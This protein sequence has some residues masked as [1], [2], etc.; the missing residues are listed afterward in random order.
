MFHWCKMTEKIKIGNRIIKFK[1]MLRNDLVRDILISGES[2]ISYSKRQKKLTT[3]IAARDYLRYY[4]LEYRH[5]KS[6]IK[7]NKDEM[8]MLE[9]RIGLR[10]V[11]YFK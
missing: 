2:G 5:L 10:G 4:N 1:D 3:K 9:E 6:K 11:D 7:L 8:K